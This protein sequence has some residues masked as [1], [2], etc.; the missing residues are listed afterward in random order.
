MKKLFP[1]FPF[2]DSDDEF[3]DGCP[4]GVPISRDSDYASKVADVA[5]YVLSSIFG[6]PPKKI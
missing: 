4:P 2:P 3:P 6:D 1:N 5:A